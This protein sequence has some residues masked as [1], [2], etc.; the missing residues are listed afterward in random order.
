MAKQPDEAATAL[1]NL[2]LKNSV[3]DAFPR[4]TR[5]A[6]AVPDSDGGDAADGGGAL[7]SVQKAS[8]RARA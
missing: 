6:P 5:L 8:A 7:L 1:E 2:A 4:G 3:P